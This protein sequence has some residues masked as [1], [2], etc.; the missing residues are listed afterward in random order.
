MSII[1]LTNLLFF[2]L[3][4]LFS[5]YLRTFKCKSMRMRIIMKP[6]FRACCNLEENLRLPGSDI[7]TSF[8][9]Y[10]VRHNWPTTQNINFGDVSKLRQSKI[11]DI[12]FSFSFYS[13]PSARTVCVNEEDSLSISLSFLRRETRSL[14]S[15]SG[16]LTTRVSRVN[17]SPYTFSHSHDFPT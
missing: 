17:T 1:N 9:V 3:F 7:I 11:D 4:F 14:R 10:P 15:V 12:S 16:F 8:L 5:F 6:Q 13:F 2:S